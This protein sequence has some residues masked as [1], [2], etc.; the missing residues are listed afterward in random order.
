[1]AS[2]EGPML[3]LWVDHYAAQVGRE[4]LVVFDDG[5]TDGSTDDLGCTVHRL[6]ALPGAAGFERARMGLMSGMA[7][8]LLAAYDYVVFVDVDE[9]LV[10][11]PKVASGLPD[12]LARRGRPEVVGVAGLNVVHVPQHEAPLDLRRPI[13]EQRSYAVFTPLMCKPAVK[14]VPARWRDSSHG[15]Q[16]RYDIDPGLF[17]LHLKFADRD[18][19]AEMSGLRHAAAQSDGRAGRSSWAKPADV[20]VDALDAVVAGVD[21]ATVAEFDPVSSTAGVVREIDGVWRGPRE[22]Q[23][24]ALRKHPVVRIPSRLRGAL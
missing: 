24:E 4:H 12:L 21:P 5:S 8:G 6:P 10:C 16:A 17:M 13:L 11:D 14:R 23:L 20:L 7:K 18:R 22:G 19:L 3:R 1:M 9:F 2:N 15:I